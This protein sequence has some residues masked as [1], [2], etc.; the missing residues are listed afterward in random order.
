LAPEGAPSLPPP[1]GAFPLPA[2]IASLDPVVL[3]PPSPW[4]PSPLTLPAPT[5]IAEPPAA[6]DPGW[7]LVPPLSLF[8]V[9]KVRT[10]L[11]PRGIGTTP[12]PNPSWGFY[13]PPCSGCF[14][15]SSACFPLSLASARITTGPSNSF[16]TRSRVSDGSGVHTARRPGFR[17][18][19]G[20][21][22][23]GRLMSGI[24][25]VRAGRLRL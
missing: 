11:S 25:I 8:E 24:R 3:F 22:R 1:R 21:A 20:P 18:P 4:L 2:A 6:G 13:C 23:F 7:L 15:L 9:L 10:A 19:S 16:F 5:S 14:P 12:R 17:Y